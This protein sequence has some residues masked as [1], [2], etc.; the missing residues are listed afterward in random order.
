MNLGN[1]VNHKEQPVSQSG[2]IVEP[3]KKTVPLEPVESPE[4]EESVKKKKVRTKAEKK[5]IIIGG[6]TM[7]LALVIG[8]VMLIVVMSL[9]RV[10][11]GPVYQQGLSLY[12]NLSNYLSES[13]CKKVSILVSNNKTSINTYNEYIEECKKDAE[14]I[15]EDVEEFVRLSIINDNTELRDLAEKFMIVFERDAPGLDTLEDTLKAYQA[16]HNYWL[17]IDGVDF[18]NDSALLPVESFKKATKYLTDSDKNIL[19]VHGRKLVVQYEELYAAWS[20]Y[21]E[22]KEAF[23]STKPNEMYYETNKKAL[24]SAESEYLKLKERFSA[25][26]STGILSDF[27]LAES[28]E[29]NKDNMKDALYNLLNVIKEKV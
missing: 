17:E 1:F 11:Y 2:S 28:N 27:P 21:I 15:N 29:N 22:A 13:D 14:E 3:K 24:E 4:P 25:Y 16:L 20:K 18:D 12:S 10:D 19:R 7:G 23:S 5:R 8:I 6:V 26:L 9:T